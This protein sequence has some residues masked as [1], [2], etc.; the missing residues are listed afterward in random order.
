MGWFSEKS[1]RVKAKRS[2][3]G[4]GFYVTSSVIFVLWTDCVH[5]KSYVDMLIPNGMVSADGMLGDN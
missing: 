5:P 2:R 1:L 4:V 3:F